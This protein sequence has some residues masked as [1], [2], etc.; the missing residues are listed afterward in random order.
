MAP[1]LRLGDGRIPFDDG[2]FGFVFSNQVVEHVADLDDVVAE[3]AR[4]TAS[5]G[6]GLH[7]WPGK[8]RPV[9]PH[10]GAPFVHWLPKTRVRLAAMRALGCGNQYRY[11]VEETFYRPHW[12]VW[13]AFDRAGFETEWVRHP[14]CPPLMGPA[15][16]AVRQVTLATR[17]R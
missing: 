4:V 5:G 9:E 7:D 2:E 3:V 13:Q 1:Y 14:K 16:R 11:S 6:L 12:I 8:W 17:L 10:Y 15:F